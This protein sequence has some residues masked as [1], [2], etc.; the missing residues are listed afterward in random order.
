[1]RYFILIGIMSY[2]FL[3]CSNRNTNVQL[4]IKPPNFVDLSEISVPPKRHNTGS[5]FDDHGLNLFGSRTARKINDLI[6]ITINQTSSLSIESQK[7]LS[8]K[9][10]KKISGGGLSTKSKSSLI[11]DIVSG[12]NDLTNFGLE[13]SGDSTF[14]GKGSTSRTDKLSTNISARIVKILKNDSF[15]IAGR[16]NVI[17]NDQVQVL[18]VSGVIR[19]EDININ[20]TIDSKYIAESK[21]LYLTDGDIAEQNSLSWGSSLLNTL[22]PY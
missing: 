22:S 13:T 4:N 8:K 11:G 17:I 3:G 2:V 16:R 14:N 19:A 10:N 1:M 15:Y 9:D 21:I 7:A 18:Y 6:N 12:I 20:N 5:L